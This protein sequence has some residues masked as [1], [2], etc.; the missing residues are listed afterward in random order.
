[1]SKVWSKRFD[2]TLNPF[3]EKF[4][5]SISFDRKLILEDLDC[6][7]AHAKMLGKTEVLSS[8][9]SLQIING[10]LEFSGVQDETQN[11]ISYNHDVEL[12]NFTFISKIKFEDFSLET[13]NPNYGLVIDSENFRYKFAMTIE[14]EQYTEDKLRLKFSY[15]SFDSKCYF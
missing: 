6:S 10:M 12:T 2:N 15:Y 8:S 7:I 11:L 4:N 13:I 9:E 14:Q 1:M 3:I 5:A